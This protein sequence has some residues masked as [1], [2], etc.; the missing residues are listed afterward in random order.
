[1]TASGRLF[2]TWAAATWKARLP[3]VDSLMGGMTRRLVLADRRAR[4]PGR[5]VPDIVARCRELWT[6]VCTVILRSGTRSQRSVANASVMWSWCE[7]VCVC[8]C[9][10]VC[11][12]RHFRTITFNLL[13]VA[14]YLRLIRQVVVNWITGIKFW[15]ERWR[16]QLYRMLWNTRISYSADAKL[17]IRPLFHHKKQYLYHF[18]C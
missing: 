15:S 17:I 6:L 13:L 7:C 3:T 9:L 10:C 16:W 2:Q 5:S 11:L 4:R 8:V 12:C 1:M 14:G 18:P